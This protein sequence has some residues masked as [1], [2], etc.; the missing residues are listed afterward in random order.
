MKSASFTAKEPRDKIKL[1]QW[2]ESKKLPFTVTVSEG[3]KRSSDQNRLQFLWMKEAEAQGDQTA[4]EY[5]ALCKLRIGIPILRYEDDSFRESYDAVF[6]DLDY[7]RK[8]KVIQLFDFPVTSLMTSKQKTTYLDRVY[9]YLTAECG[10]M[11][12]EPGQT[13]LEVY[14]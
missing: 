13:P 4:E 10:F 1:T 9:Q 2:L 11:L 7:D 8:L 14:S 5:R 12:T 6:K 3:N